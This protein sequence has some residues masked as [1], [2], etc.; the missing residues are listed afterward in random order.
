MASHN[1]PNLY[2]SKHFLSLIIF[3]GI[4]CN[5]SPLV[6]LEDLT[7]EHSSE[8][9]VEKQADGTKTVDSSR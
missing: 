4:Q 2:L 5:C 3:Q 6:S 8:P 7:V 9:D 1:V